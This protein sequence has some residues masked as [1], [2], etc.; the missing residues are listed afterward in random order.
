MFQKIGVG[1][2]LCFLC[3][4]CFSKKEEE[5]ETGY[6]QIT[7]NTLLL[8]YIDA[9]E[10]EMALAKIDGEDVSYDG[11]YTLKEEKLTNEE[12]MTLET[13]IKTTKQ[14]SVLFKIQNAKVVYAKIQFYTHL[15]IYEEGEITNQEV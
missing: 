14:E 3:T 2:L 6:N 15:A 10:Q 8:N 9:I 4:G 11:S 12:G 5:K 13:S 1:I 7:V